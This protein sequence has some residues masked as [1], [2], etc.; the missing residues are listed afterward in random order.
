MCGLLWRSSWS[1]RRPPRRLQ[2]RRCAHGGEKARWLCCVAWPQ[3]R[4]SGEVERG[5]KADVLGSLADGV[6]LATAGRRAC[7]WLFF[8]SAGTCRASAPVATR[9]RGRAPRQGLRRGRNGSK[10]LPCDGHDR[11]HARRYRR[12]YVAWWAAS[13][14]AHDELILPQS[15]AYGHATG[16]SSHATGRP[17]MLLY[18]MAVVIAIISTLLSEGQA[19]RVARKL[20]ARA[21]R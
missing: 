2:V 3:R 4:L 1:R 5:R 11:V 19:S 14:A 10:L 15:A 20:V 18:R 8:R 13:A 21:P 6:G 12:R 9:R 7:C 17:D 16:P